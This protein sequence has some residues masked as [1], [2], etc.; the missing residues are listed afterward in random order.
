MVTFGVNQDIQKKILDLTIEHINVTT[1]SAKQ[2]YE[3]EQRG[4]IR[5]AS[6]QECFRKT[7][8]VHIS[9]PASDLSFPESIIHAMMNTLPFEIC[10][11]AG[12]LHDNQQ[13]T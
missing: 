7:F 4:L 2:L 3:A 12:I 8:F 10:Y 5:P 1:K 11:Y 13:P 6:L 9:F